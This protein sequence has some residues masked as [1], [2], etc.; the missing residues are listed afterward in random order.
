MRRSGAGPG[1]QL[2][3]RPCRRSCACPRKEG[4]GK[5]MPAQAGAQ[6][7]LQGIIPGQGEAR[8]GCWRA[9]LDR[10]WSLTFFWSSRQPAGLCLDLGLGWA[11]N[12]PC[13]PGGYP[14]RK[15]RGIVGEQSEKLACRP[16]GSWDP[17]GLW[18]ERRPGEPGPTGTWPVRRPGGRSLSV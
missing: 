4:S 8:D 9:L 17:K 2:C 1:G 11:C 16:L 15:P 3:K 12:G 5:E 10:G 6:R 13:H 14:W 7:P 18:E